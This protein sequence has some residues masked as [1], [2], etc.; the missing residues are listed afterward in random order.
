MRSPLSLR[1][2][3]G[4]LTQTG[5][6]APCITMSQESVSL[7]KLKGKGFAECGKERIGS[8]VIPRWSLV[9]QPEINQRWRLKSPNH[10]TTKKFPCI[11]LMV[12][13]IRSHLPMQRTP[14]SIPGPGRFQ[15]PSRN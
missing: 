2:W 8:H 7:R 1:S 13:W 4:S 10:W 5:Y 12:Q 3:N 9:P 6:L 14:P 11:S 15:L